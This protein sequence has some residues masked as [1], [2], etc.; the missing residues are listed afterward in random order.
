MTSISHIF[1]T[2]YLFLNKFIPKNGIANANGT[3]ASSSETIFFSEIPT[4]TKAIPILFPMI[5]SAKTGLFMKRILLIAIV[6]EPIRI[7]SLLMMF[8]V[9]L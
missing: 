4:S 3:N 8:S 7:E 6:S 1:C 2:S 5:L 9:P